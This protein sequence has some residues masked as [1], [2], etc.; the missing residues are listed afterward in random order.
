[1]KIY[2][3]L[4]FAQ[5]EGEIIARFGAARL[6][7]KPDGRHELIGGTPAD[8]TD[9]LEWCSMFHHDLVFSSVPRHNPAVAFA[10]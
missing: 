6:I 7:R 1:M 5:D 10:A 4:S 3:L 9:A 8:H 2:R